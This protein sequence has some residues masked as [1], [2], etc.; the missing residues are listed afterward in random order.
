MANFYQEEDQPFR[1]IKHNSNLKK[2]FFTSPQIDTNSTIMNESNTGKN[3][4]SKRLS[5]ISKLILYS[6]ETNSYLSPTYRDQIKTLSLKNEKNKFVKNELT[7]KFD[8][9]N[10]KTSK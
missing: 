9:I 4:E 1:K 7:H 3:K 10:K 8:K 6:L 5:A 2:A